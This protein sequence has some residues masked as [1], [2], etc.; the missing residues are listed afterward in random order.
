MQ[1]D[2]ELN[3]HTFPPGGGWKFRQPQMNWDNP[4]AMVGFKASVDAIRKVRTANP[5][6]TTKHQ[7]STDPDVIEGELL[8]FTRQRLGIKDTPS[9]FRRSR[10]LVAADVAAAKAKLVTQFRRA[11][12]GAETWR[13]L[14]GEKGEPVPHDLAEQRAS[15][16]VDCP[17]NKRGDLLSFF[18]RPVA[19]QLLKLLEEMKGRNLSTSHD[20]NI[21]VCDACGCPLK[22]KV[23][24]P[25]DI[26]R[27]HMKDEERSKLDARC[28]IL[29]EP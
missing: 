6:I 22:A 17:Q 25:V 27:R 20:A 18:Y 5:A 19:N 15:V 9:F 14:F 10:N 29:R 21:N 26:T 3:E 8:A 2:I 16:C 28:W 24:V 12:T 7:L 4:F 1:T 23:H 13:E 11:N